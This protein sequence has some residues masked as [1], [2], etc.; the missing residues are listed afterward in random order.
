[1]VFVL[2]KVFFQPLHDL[3]LLPIMMKVIDVVSNVKTGISMPTSLTMSLACILAGLQGWVCLSSLHSTF[4]NLCTP[5]LADHCCCAAN[6]FDSI[7]KKH[8]EGFL[9]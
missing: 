4:P 5:L 1:M 6:A 8:H 2:C 3:G 7:G 9:F